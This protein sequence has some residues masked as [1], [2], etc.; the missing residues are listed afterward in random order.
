MR[1][2]RRSAA[3]VAGLVFAALPLLACEAEDG[4][5]SRAGD[6]RRD[7]PDVAAPAPDAGGADDVGVPAPDGS[8]P[9]G[10]DVGQPPVGPA[11]RWALPAATPPPVGA[12]PAALAWVAAQVATG[13]TL[14]RVE[15]DADGDGSFEQV[16]PFAPDANGCYPDGGA[17][18]AP[19]VAFAWAWRGDARPAWLPGT[20]VRTALVTAARGADGERRVVLDVE[21]WSST[22]RERFERTYDAAGRLTGEAHR[23]SGALWFER[24]L[25][26][27]GDR[28]TGATLTD[29][30]NF[31]APRTWT[32]TWTYDAAGRLAVARVDRESGPGDETVVATWT[33]DDAGRPARVERTQGGRPWIEQT[34]AYDAAGRLRERAVTVQPAAW[35]GQPVVDDHTPGH[36][37]ARHE[38]DGADA[39]P[40]PLGDGAVRLPTA[41][42]HG[43][44]PG[45]RVYELGWPVAE[46]PAGIGFDYGYEGYAHF[47]GDG[48]W[49]GHGGVGAGAPPDSRQTLRHT[50]ITYDERGR[51]VRE[52]LAEQSA[53]GGT[54]R[55]VR[56][57]TFDG[58]RLVR[59]ER[60]AAERTSL[61]RF[62]WDQ[63][64]RL[65]ERTYELAGR[66]VA[67]HTWAYDD[68]GRVRTHGVA[69]HGGESGG[70][71]GQEW[72]WERAAPDLSPFEGAPPLRWVHERL[73]SA[74]GRRVEQRKRDAR[75]GS[76]TAEAEEERD[77]AGR[78]VRR[79][80]AGWTE[81][82]AFDDAGR[83]LRHETDEG[84]ADAAPERGVALA[85]DAAGRLTAHETFAPGERRARRYA[86]TCDDA[87]AR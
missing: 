45:E 82:W 38:D 31:P 72:E 19:L 40:H 6:G 22:A 16:V 77:A 83:L 70:F 10:P 24:A 9:G 47:Y 75:A 43:Y 48:A 66:R 67:A 51:A 57:R 49:F 42:G 63:D 50:A 3:L 53:G 68:A 14:A 4:A 62:A 25:A 44:P 81:T 87:P 26:W 85:Y 80:R 28:P 71:V 39:L 32:W 7:R 79:T 65:A 78:L 11:P 61:L 5:G 1:A 33:Y 37:A 74:D 46:R 27:D 21:R 41:A 56:E 20:D 13:C 17:C 73:W 12:A 18:G 54:Q 29:H 59:D 60:T 69:W 8:E 23:W 58:D 36:I 35:P 30:V 52:E 2:R 76:V 84:G 86:Y 55:T 64:G 34:W 15:T